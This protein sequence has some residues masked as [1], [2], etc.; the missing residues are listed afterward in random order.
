VTF[1]DGTKESVLNVTPG[2]KIQVSAVFPPANFQ[3]KKIENNAL[4]YRELIFELSWA[5][6]PLN[7]NVAKYRLYDVT[8]TQTLLAE[9]PATQL[10][11]TLRN[12][13]RT[14]TYHFALTAVDA[15]GGESG[16]ALSAS[17]A[18][19]VANISG[20]PASGKVLKVIK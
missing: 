7:L 17:A 2:Q 10:S 15:G 13:D 19:R 6:N 5:A 18:G 14:K 11:Y 4:F 8:Q 20:R 12:M 3:V 1:L 16:P 9:L